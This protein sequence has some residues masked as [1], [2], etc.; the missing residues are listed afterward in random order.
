MRSRPAQPHEQVVFRGEIS[1]HRRNQLKIAGGRG[2]AQAGRLLHV[3]PLWSAVESTEPRVRGGP[4]ER[5]RH[6]PKLPPSPL[7]P[8]PPPTATKVQSPGAQVGLWGNNALL[9]AAVNTPVTTSRWGQGHPGQ[10]PVCCRTCPG[11]LEG[12]F[13]SQLAEGGAGKCSPCGALAC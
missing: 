2:R 7:T 10:T 4:S 5:R 11:V 8:P 9:P 3:W 6:A 13:S 12:P 1:L